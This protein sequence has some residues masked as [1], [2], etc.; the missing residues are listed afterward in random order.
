MK[1]YFIILSITAVLFT[2][3]GNLQDLSGLIGTNKNSTS[4]TTTEKGGKV[5]SDILNQVFGGRELNV[6]SMSGTWSYTGTA[7][8]FETENLL[9]KAGGAVVATQVETELDKTIT[10]IG[11][12]STNTYFI[13][14]SDNSYSAKFAGIPFSG[15]YT[16]NPTTKRVKMTYLMGLATMDGAVVLTSNNMQLLFDADAMLKLI[17][18]LS[19]FSND[20]SIQVLAKMADMY[21]G[22]LLGFDL[23]KQ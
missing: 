22:L 7:A 3:C 17:K 23:K 13:F 12:K 20:T 10:K 9:K 18:V 11:V 16:I 5:L 15:K 21:D 19:K 4:T 14:N 8:A 6:E 1:K 2:S